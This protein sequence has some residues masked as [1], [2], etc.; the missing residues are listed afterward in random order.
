MLGARAIARGLTGT[1]G[2]V[3]ALPE[4][5][6]LPLVPLERLVFGGWEVGG[7]PLV[8]QARTLAR[9]HR[10]LPAELVAALEDDL[11][12]VDAE[13][14]TGFGAP[15]RPPAEAGQR[16]TAPDSEPLG[17]ASE[18]L[19]RDLARFREARGLGTVVVVNVASTEPPLEPRPE[20]QR[21]AD[22]EELLRRDR[23][24][25]VAPS[26]LYAYV[27]LASGCPYVNF[28]PSPGAS[29]GALRELAQVRGVPY[30]GNDGKTGE[31]LVR[32]VLA[33]LFAC[34]NLEVLAWHG[35]N[36]LGGGDGRVLADPGPRGAKVRSKH[37]VLERL[38]GYRPEGGIAIEYLPSLGNWKTAWDYVCFRG[39]LGTSM[40]LQFVWQGCDSA[41]AAPLVLDLARLA[42]FAQ[43]CGEAGPMYHLACFFKDPLD[44][45]VHALG[46]QYRML[47]D[48]VA[49]HTRAPLRP[50]A[51]GRREERA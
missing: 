7:R 50:V 17:E 1:Q 15:R 24:E 35:V 39:F 22:F 30:Y 19:R 8:E 33:P 23:R 51:S 14:R 40:T 10:S 46:E 16:L 18:R 11:R 47:V 37:V 41:L 20:H 48:Y 13:I 32:S 36:L 25:A 21:L 43:R 26:M 4:I 3:T 28:T 6:A 9:E 38:L 45:A 34:R 5:S 2:L 44:V 29:L 42:E 27:A 12:A 49:R 31:T